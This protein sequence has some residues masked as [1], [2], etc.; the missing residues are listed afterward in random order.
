M[1]TKQCLSYVDFLGNSALQFKTDTGSAYTDYICVY[2]LSAVREISI[3]NTDIANSAISAITAVPITALNWNTLLSEG[4]FKFVKSSSE[5]Y[6]C[7]KFKMSDIAT[8][9][10]VEP[11]V[12]YSY[13][14]L[15]NDSV[16]NNMQSST[17]MQYKY[18]YSAYNTMTPSPV[19]GTTKTTQDLLLNNFKTTNNLES[20]KDFVRSDYYKFFVPETNVIHSRSMLELND[21]TL[22]SVG[23]TSHESFNCLLYCINP[24]FDPATAGTNGLPKGFVNGTI[25]NAVPISLCTYTKDIILAGKNVRF[26]PNLNG[27]A[28]VE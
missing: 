12:P 14:E 19:A 20:D 28:T 22:A 24:D 5:E 13:E 25:M 16:L 7:Y 3:D 18:I 2:A 23:N 6:M 17:G 10:D 15:F 27:I 11:D 26:E 8:E 4:K 21:D 1:A 9:S